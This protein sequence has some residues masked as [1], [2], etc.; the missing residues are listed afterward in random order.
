MQVT[1]QIAF[2]ILKK[3]RMKKYFAVQLTVLLTFA[4]LITGC[5]KDNFRGDDLSLNANVKITSFTANGV[6]GVINDQAGTISIELPFGTDLS[7]V[8][9]IV[10]VPEGATV[11]P[12]SGVMVNLK[13]GVKYRVMNGNIYTDYI[14]TATEK[15]AL[16]E[17]KVA[18]VVATIDELRR[19]IYAVVPD[20]VNIA[21][22][23]PI[24]T[25]ASG[26]TIT[27]A[28]GSVVNL[29]DSV[30]YTVTSGSVSIPYTAKVVKA[31]SVAKVAFIGTSADSLSITNPDEKAAATWLFSNPNAEYISINEIKSGTANLSSFKVVW[32]HEDATQA[33]PSLAFDA[34]VINN[35]KT[36]RNN[37]G[38]ILLSSYGGQYLE[39][40]GVV[41]GGK[42]PN[43][44]FGDNTPW[45]EANND[46]GISYKTTN[47]HPIFQGLTTTPE[48]P[49]PTAYLL[50]K[51]TFRLNHTAVWKVNEW[52]G[53]G[54]IANWRTQTGG[55]D[56]ASTEW[57]E[58]HVNHVNIAE[59]PRTTTNGPVIAIVS[60][61]YDW[62]NEPNPANGNP[63]AANIW[64]SNITTLTKNT[65]QYLSR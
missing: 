53:Y 60:G 56:L 21:S 27:P 5:K 50:A 7:A 30:I 61:S 55:I 4:V 24:I 23:A 28:S 41:P 9:P 14:V 51:G 10:S 54:T 59:F 32:W 64:L 22:L 13:S 8:A 3:S 57:D 42:G 29:T 11:S 40:L 62:F 38:A 18:G 47:T 49:Y 63:S 16:I 25:L 15:K 37:G 43:N 2:Q 26:A 31:S 46:W 35:L 52:G 6:N 36:Y 45:L 33:L 20:S 48:K 19:T 17:F 1:N 58:D 39:A 65:L 34:D 12:S 44:V